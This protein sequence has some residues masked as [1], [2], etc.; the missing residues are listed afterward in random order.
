MLIAFPVFD[1]ITALDAVGP[2]EVLRMLPGAEVVFTAARPGPVQAPSGLSLLATHAYDEI[3]SC[4]VLVVPGG[5]GAR[6][7]LD[8]AALTG[9]IRQMDA[10]SDWTTSVCTG[11]LLL[12]AAGLLDGLDATT[13][14]SAAG[15][16]AR[17]GARYVPDRVVRQG[18]VI[19]AAGVSAGID[20]ALTLAALLTDEVTAQACQLRIEYDPQP[21]F[22]SGS[23]AKATAQVR[24]AAG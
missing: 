6:E 5:R 19:T 11:A 13:H 15:D 9:W 14:W 24:A 20:M 4:D 2:Y 23:L 1:G 16:L 12:G 8:D 22:D 17:F 18:K 3:G 21:P 7:R 10:T